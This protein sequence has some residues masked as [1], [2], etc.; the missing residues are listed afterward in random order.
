MADQGYNG[1][2]AGG[3][4]I[5]GA[6]LALLAS[7]APAVATAQ[8]SD[9]P[10]PAPSAPTQLEEIVVTAQKRSEVLTTVP[11]AISSFRGEEL[12]A[13]GVEDT[14][15]LGKVVPGFTAADSG[16]DTPTYTLRGVGFADSSFA[17]TSTVGIYDDE[18]SLAY[19]IM[20]KGPNLDLHQVEVLQGPQ[21]TLYGR[22][23]TAGTVN[24]IANKP[25]GRFSDGAEVSYGSFGRVDA[26][27]Y[28]SG[29]LGDSFKARLAASSTTSQEGWQTSATRPDDSLGKLNKQAARGI[30]DWQASDSVQL[31]LTLSGWTDKSQPEAPFAVATQA[32]FKLPLGSQFVDIL[33]SL[34]GLNIDNGF[35]D[36]SVRNYPLIPN[37]NDPRKADWNPN[38]ANEYGLHDNFWMA[39]LRPTWDITDTINLTGL[40]SFQ[41]MRAD[42]SSLPQGGMNVED[43]DQVLRA[44]IRTYQA[45]LRLSGKIGEHGDWLVGVN[46]NYDKHHEVD[47][48]LGSENSLNVFIYGD[49]APLD[50][51]LFF[52]K[53][54][55]KSAAQVQAGSA[56]AD[57]DVQLLDALKLTLGVRY[58]HEKQDYSGCTFVFA[59]NDSIIPFPF[60]T[61]ASFLKGGHSVVP[62]GQCGS[63]DANANAGLFV[64]TLS[65]H[66]LSWRSVLSW[67]PIED[68][69]FY[70]SYSRGYKA[71][72]FPTVFSVDQQSLSPVV[73]EKLDAYEVGAHYA[74]GKSLQA[75]LSGFYYNYTNKQLLTYF[76]DPI[77][78]ALQ[79]LQ[80]VPKSLDEGVQLSTTWAPVSKLFLTVAGS[81]I[82]TK[83]IEYEG[84][85]TQGNDF[86]F[87]GQPFN[88]TPRLQASL[89]A[90]YTF[91]LNRDLNLTPGGSFTYTGSTNATLEHDP[92]F[93]MNAHRIY[94]AR[95]ALTPSDR[96]WSLAAYGR[97]LGNE[98]YRNSVIKLGDSVFAY[99]GMTR[100]YGLTFTC[101]F[102]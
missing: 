38:P 1:A 30:L 48:G 23:S 77:F 56:F 84:K 63:L 79:Y 72:G 67:T 85:D 22:N 69:L 86:D 33:K 97:N 28:V 3:S 64:D 60:F 51:P 88:Y 96:T 58:T 46:G 89:L 98:F 66:N 24:Y 20:S 43:I 45:E 73:Q 39:S 18:V 81:Y 4:R 26:E 101:D 6:W 82:R 35:L 34:T 17:T 100:V 75:S 49:T 44:F 16:F 9:T 65:E 25:S 92:L 74:A 80:N 14:R 57:G 52:Q 27:G 62:Q 55:A 68:S 70:A 93:A 95:L 37:N 83:V 53:G 8:T 71:G 54:A 102:R 13:L 12:Q 94:D 42:G 59:D 36:P 31:R 2:S 21:G 32:Q 41:Q 78:G 61:A 47:E 29:P 5:A 90:N 11:M 76:K 99:A 19:P 40:F 91:A 7:A 10:A 87:A 50:K 15:D